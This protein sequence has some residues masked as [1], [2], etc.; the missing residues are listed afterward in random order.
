MAAALGKPAWPVPVALLKAA[1]A[2]RLLALAVP[3]VL[4]ALPDNTRAR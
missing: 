2:A 1:L 4:A 3:V